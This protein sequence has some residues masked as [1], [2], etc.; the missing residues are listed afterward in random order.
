MLVLYYTHGPRRR[1][2]NTTGTLYL[3]PDMETSTPLF[4]DGYTTDPPGIWLSVTEPP[5]VAC[6]EEDR[7]SRQNDPDPAARTQST[8]QP[9]PARTNHK[10]G[11][12]V[13]I[14]VCA[15][16]LFWHWVNFPPCRHGFVSLDD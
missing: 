7:R 9:G 11:E 5:L 6:R 12:S 8:N 3:F 1:K 15:C 14:I 10:V 2:A 4:V 16:V 13:E